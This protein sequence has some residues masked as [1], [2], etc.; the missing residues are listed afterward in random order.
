MDIKLLRA[1]VTLAEQGNYHAAAEAL[2]LTQSALTKQ[3]Q[4]LEHLTGV[5]L[6][7]RGRHG[8]KLTVT[9]RQL[10]GRTCELLKHHEEFLEYT[11][12]IEKGNAG[13]LALGF[14]ISSFRLAPAL[15]NLFREQFPEVEV[16][17]SDIPSNV[18]CRMLTEGQLQAG[19][20][21]L[22]MTEPLQVKVLMDENLVLAAPSGANVDP[23]D[24]RSL[25][26]K[27][28]LLQINPRRGPCLAEQVTRFLEVNHLSA[29][30]ASAADDIHALLALIAAGNG[31]ALLPSG[32]SHFLPAGVTVVRPEGM[33]TLWQIGVAWNPKI[34]DALRDKF[35]QMMSEAT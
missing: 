7:H 10:Y 8:A 30:P 6:F 34:K 3:I 26:K 16:S 5:S 22:P 9:G 1:F 13:K 15:V 33:H 32:I 21:R 18:Q 2:Y 4:A 23:A 25:F 29:K 28:P 12:S 20:I 31:V 14:G 35:L 11:R 24:I 17:L 27:H 19:F